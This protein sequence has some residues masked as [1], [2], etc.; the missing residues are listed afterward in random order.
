[1]NIKKSFFLLFFYCFF[2]ISAIA[3]KISWPFSV[4]SVEDAVF[5]LDLSFLN[6][7]LDS[8]GGTAFVVEIGGSYY[9]VTNFHIIYHLN[10]GKKISGIKNKSGQTLEMGTIEGLSFLY[11]LAVIKINKGYKGPVLKLA[12]RDENTRKAYMMGFPLGQF[13]TVEF[14]EISEISSEHFCGVTDDIRLLNGSSGGPV[15]NERGEVIGITVTG[16]KYDMEFIKS[17]VRPICWTGV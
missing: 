6:D 12:D 16:S 15:F 2:H 3:E 9:L 4:E 10:Y 13:E 17:G 14:S 8:F 1:M 7:P 5:L 11:D